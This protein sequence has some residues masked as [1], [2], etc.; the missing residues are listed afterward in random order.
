M[1]E[2]L[3]KYSAPASGRS[4]LGRAISIHARNWQANFGLG[5]FGPIL[6]TSAEHDL[7]DPMR[8]DATG[9]M[10]RR[11]P[12][13]P[14]RSR[15]PH[16]AARGSPGRSPEAALPGARPPGDRAP[17]AATTLHGVCSVASDVL[18]AAADGESTLRLQRLRLRRLLGRVAALLRILRQIIR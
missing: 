17:L 13:L 3:T 18:D 10:R 15:H 8:R 4:A 6:S 5:R 2:A 9:E 14:E 12:D 16:D 7:S 11:P 1:T